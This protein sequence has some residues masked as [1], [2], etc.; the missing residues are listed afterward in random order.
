[1]RIVTLL[2]GDIV[3][4]PPP[5]KLANYIRDGKNRRLFHP[6]FVDCKYRRKLVSTQPCGKVNVC[7]NCDLKKHI[8]SVPF[9]NGCDIEPKT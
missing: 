2:S 9:C 6:A 3:I 1:M 4:D 8:V 7:W 5:E